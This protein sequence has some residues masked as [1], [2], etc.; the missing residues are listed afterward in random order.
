MRS[1]EWHRVEGRGIKP[2]D[3]ERAVAAD[4]LETFARRPFGGCPRPTPSSAA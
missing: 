2:V 3:D 1:A 4:A